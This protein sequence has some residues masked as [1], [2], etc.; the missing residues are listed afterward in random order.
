MSDLNRAHFYADLGK[1]EE[2][3]KA[4]AA[5]MEKLPDFVVE[6]AADFYRRLQFEDAYID[7]MVQALKKAGLPSRGDS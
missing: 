1:Q 7:K 3:E 4:A 2:A 5:L 6:D